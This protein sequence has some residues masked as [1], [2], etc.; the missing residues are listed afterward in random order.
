MRFGVAGKGGVG[1]TTISAVLARSLSQ[2]GHRV[3][4]I[5]CDSDPNLA[6]NVGLATDEVAAMRPL[7]D[8]SGPVRSVPADASPVSLVE[9]YGRAGPDDVTLMLAARAEKAGSG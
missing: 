4:A 7:L 2:R 1:K 6:A 8:Q 5:D 9:T 3:V